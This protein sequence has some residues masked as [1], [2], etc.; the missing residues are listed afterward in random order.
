[1]RNKTETGPDRTAPLLVNMSPYGGPDASR[2]AQEEY[3]E[4]CKLLVDQ[5]DRLLR[6][7]RHLV[8]QEA[9][10]DVPSTDKLL[11]RRIWTH[12][13]RELLSNEKKALALKVKEFCG[14][15]FRLAVSCIGTT[16][17]QHLQPPG[18]RLQLRHP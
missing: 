14:S 8:F 4:A 1:M 3:D 15:L 10:R 11:V 6:K 16:R 9:S 7:H 17:F 5:S 2:T 12:N 13:E 18:L